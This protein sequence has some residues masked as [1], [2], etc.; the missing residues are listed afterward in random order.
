MKPRDHVVSSNAARLG[1]REVDDWPPRKRWHDY[2]GSAQANRHVVWPK[3][4]FDPA[5]DNEHM[6]QVFR[7]AILHR[8]ETGDG[9][10]FADELYG[11]SVELNLYQE[12]EAMLTR[13]GGMGAGLWLRNAKAE[14]DSA[15]WD[16]HFRL[17]TRRHGC[18]LAV[19]P[20]RPTVNAS[21]RWK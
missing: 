10:T 2:L 14:R 16:N 15:R 20:L 21:G 8:Y 17:T 5:A 6:R 3:H 12:T 18:S 7:R 13:G 11:L 1:L 4:S 9:I 19:T